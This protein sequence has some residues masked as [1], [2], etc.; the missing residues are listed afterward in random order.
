[1]RGRVR[2]L[3]AAGGLAVALLAAGPAFAN[4][5]ITSTPANGDTY[6]VGEQITTR[7]NHGQAFGVAGNFTTI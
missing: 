6:G 1:M 5:T 7:F 4:P 3:A 2:A